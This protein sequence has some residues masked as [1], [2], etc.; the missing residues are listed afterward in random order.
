MVNNR[1]LNL[2]Q[3]VL[4]RELFL[5][6]PRKL[7]DRR[8]GRDW[9]MDAETMVGTERLCSLT[10]LCQDVYARSIPGDF[11]ECGVWKGGCAIMMAAVVEERMD[12]GDHPYQPVRNVWVVDS[13]QG[14]P[15]PNPELYPADLND[16]H[17]SLQFLAVSREEVM[18]NFNRYGLLHPNVKFLPGWFKDTLPGPIEKLAVLRLDGDLYEST[19]QCL[20][21]LYEKVSPGG[22]VIVDDYGCVPGCRQAVDN[23]REVRNIRNPI[24]QID[25]T[26]IWWQ[27]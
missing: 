1:Y 5:T 20:K 18:S 27:V 2:L 9:P 16:N 8:H 15:K 17:H 26:G 14:C 10:R 7:Q 6:D 22:Y 13:F 21:A 3:K 24:H 25:W 11:A 19:W 23:F 4:T 12:S